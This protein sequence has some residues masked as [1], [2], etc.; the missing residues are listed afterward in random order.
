MLRTALALSALTGKAF[1]MKNIRAG[2]KQPG[3]KAQH[4]QCVKAVAQ[5]C[6][7][8]TE[9][10][11]E[12][13]SE[14]LFVPRKLSV[15]N[16]EIDIGTAGSITLLLQALLLP[17]MFGHKSHTITA[18]G[19]T[20]VAWSM[21]V[22]YFANVVIPQFNRVC[23]IEVKVL[24]RGYYPKGGGRVQVVVKPQ[25]SL[26]KAG[27][28]DG[29]LEALKEKK[30]LLIERGK[31]MKVKGVAHASK[32]LIDA[33]VA[34]R[35][36]ASAK[37]ELISLGVP[38]DCSFEYAATESPGAGISIWAIYS[39]KDDDIDAQN[40]V[41]LGADSLGEQGK[42]SESVGQ[43]AAAKLRKEMIAPVDSHLADN[44]IPL[45]ALCG[46]EMEVSQ[47]T[48]HVLTNVE[49]IKAFLGGCIEIKG[50][51]VKKVLQV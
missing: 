47:I 46:G 31:L 10:A 24:K 33:R 49:V 37:Q 4:L 9:G 38:T 32:D 23:N 50:N 3:L 30:F 25:F 6:E 5:I 36:A 45:L 13:S 44:L 35:M 27:S 19:G 11:N 8:Y 2:R 7:G 18:I 29:L 16:V 26:K 41:R 39:L 51:R 42:K 40:P 21:P 28:F 17:C 20:D 48:P 34:E 1:R 14:L 22:D 15:K 43:D 12:G